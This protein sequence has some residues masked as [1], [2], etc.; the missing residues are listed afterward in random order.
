M[1]KRSI[2]LTCIVAVM[3]LAMFV[4][5]DNAPVLPSFVV[6]GTINQTGDFL[7]GQTF[8]P[9][10]FTVTI[11]YDNGRIVAADE[12]VSVYLD[13]DKNSD[14]KVNAGDTVKADLGKNY[15]D[16]DICATAGISVY[17]I[18]SV[19]VVGP[20]TIG[21]NNMEI[22]ASDLTVTATYL[23]STNSEK[24][25]VLVPGEYTV[26]EV[27][28]GNVTP[29]IPEA[30]ASVEVTVHVG[31]FGDDE[32]VYT[33]DFTVE[34]EEPV[35]VDLP[36]EITGW[37]SDN[38]VEFTGILMQ[39]DY[40]D[41]A[42]EPNPSDVTLNVRGDDGEDHTVNAADVEGVELAFVDTQMGLPLASNDLT[43]VSSVNLVVSLPG[44]AEQ[45][46]LEVETTATFLVV[47]PVADFALSEGPLG[48]ASASDY[49]VILGAG[50]SYYEDITGNDGISVIY[51]A[52]D[53]S[54]DELDPETVITTASTVYA[55]ANYMGA[56]GRTDD[57][58]T[59]T[60]TPD[61]TVESIE[62]TLV[63]GFEGPVAQYYD[64]LST[65]TTDF[66]GSDAIESVTY[67]MSDG[68]ER[69]FAWAGAGATAE[70][71]LNGAPLSELKATEDGDYD[72][73]VDSLDIHVVYGKVSV[74]VPVATT[75]A[76][77]TRLE[78]IATVV[79]AAEA[80]TVVGMDVEYAVVLKNDTGAIDKDYTD[81]GVLS[82][83]YSAELPAT[84]TAADQTVTVYNRA[85][86]SMTYDVTVAAG[87]SYISAGDLAFVQQ[88]EDA[89]FA[90]G[91]E[92]DSSWVNANFELDAETYD[93]IS[94]NGA[95]AEITVGA[96]V[97]PSGKVLETGENVI[98]VTVTYL[99]AEGTTVTATVNLTVT[100]TAYITS[101][102]FSLMY[103]NEP[104]TGL[105]VGRSY[106]RSGFSVNPSSY[107]AVGNNPE[108]SITSITFNG[109]EVESSF[110]VE[111]AYQ[112][113]VFG[114][115]YMSG[116]SS[117]SGIT[118]NPAAPQNVTINAVAAE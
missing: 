39:L 91:T 71:Y 102:T 47:T 98:P 83:G 49:K 118:L 42:V 12:T 64:S 52:S 58:L 16:S 90:V 21:S 66:D 85:N 24:T 19:E 99:G 17:N 74:D 51:V 115:Q 2:L 114:I 23:D 107:T 63:E 32:L 3:A 4:G 53:S 113:F 20:E 60:E 59:I 117:G 28:G 95:D 82:N 9:S 79:K 10:K 89:L 57:K 54:T 111:N 73:N 109:G 80:T 38:T 81:I 48:T 108:T 18:K 61:P 87:A 56:T 106:N 92:I 34:Y 112:T 27:S 103:N 44:V 67:V 55:Y 93:V 31:N 104:I 6:G 72:L 88:N 37:A 62:V 11:T 76:E 86:V 116:S 35:P 94:G 22:S 1:K 5:C 68:S 110:T 29:S 96:P 30:A 100:G 13:T 14:G 97:V 7:E 46:T 78:V 101:P 84:V 69:E 43:S 65:L 15:A 77:A 8:D 75:G 70:Y 45:K 41:N 40:G 36:Y 26:G 105:V 33:Y 50:G 25:M